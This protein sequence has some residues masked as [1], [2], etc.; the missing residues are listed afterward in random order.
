M[1]NAN[2]LMGWAASVAGLGMATVYLSGCAC[3]SPSSQATPGEPMPSGFLYRTNYHGWADAIWM[4][5]GHVEAIIV[6]AVGRVMQFRWAG[7]EDG[8]FWENPD[9]A[10]E[11]G[12]DPGGAEAAQWRNYG[13]DRV[14]PSPQLEWM[15]VMETNWPPP[16]GFDGSAVEAHIDGWVVTLVYPTD[17]DFGIRATRRIELVP[18]A[19]AMEILTEYE[20]MDRKTMDLGVWV[21]TQLKEPLSLHA[22]LPELSN[23]PQGFQPMSGRLPPSQVF[24]I[25]DRLLTLG[26][27]PENSHRLGLEVGSVVWMDDTTVLKIESPRLPYR[28][29]PEK[30][31]SAIVSTQADPQGYVEIEMLGPVRQVRRGDVLRQRSTY[32]LMRRSELDAKLEAARFLRP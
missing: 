18:G 25:R 2:L 30:G 21:L 9:L 15:S 22:R 12:E 29:Y 20:K 7:A 16:V 1:K 23:F 27:D 8:P 32:T 3:C 5:N 14:W 28:N 17:A 4:G 13:G 11:P 24:E 31:V 19:P 26:R 10:G 6:P